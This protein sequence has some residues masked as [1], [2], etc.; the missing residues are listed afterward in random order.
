M[1]EGH[2]PGPWSDALLRAAAHPSARRQASLAGDTRRRTRRRWESGR[3]T[4]LR[5]LQQ[6][7]EDEQ[8][9]MLLTFTV[10]YMMEYRCA[11]LVKG[12]AFGFLDSL[13]MIA[14][15]NNNLLTKCFLLV[16]L[17]LGWT[18]RTKTTITT[19]RQSNCV[20]I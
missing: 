10:H 1:T 3:H 9:F 14:E 5:S 16:K 15:S 13:F 19:T 6:M 20:Y 18:L 12:R 4:V 17:M 2:G 11:G 7:Q 8:S